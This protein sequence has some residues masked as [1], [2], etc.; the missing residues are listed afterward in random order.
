MEFV[1][2]AHC[3]LVAQ[4]YFSI[5]YLFSAFGAEVRIANPHQMGLPDAG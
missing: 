1:F 3:V 4:I 5:I 2:S